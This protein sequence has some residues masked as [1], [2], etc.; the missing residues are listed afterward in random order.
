MM[1][2]MV[3]GRVEDGA[4][5]SCGAAVGFGTSFF[6]STVPL[7]KPN[8]VRRRYWLQPVKSW[9]LLVNMMLPST[10]LHVQSS[11]SAEA[12]SGRSNAEKKATKRGMP[13]RCIGRIL[14]NAAKPYSRLAYLFAR[15]GASPLSH[16]PTPGAPRRAPSR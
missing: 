3:I 8:S 12:G 11:D 5:G 13:A 10:R 16:P 15:G 4:V 6:A 1:M 7:K 2:L 9:L 14:R